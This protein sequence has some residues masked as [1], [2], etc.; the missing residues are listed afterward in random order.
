MSVKNRWRLMAEDGKAIMRNQHRKFE[1]IKY[2]FVSS[3]IATFSVMAAAGLFFGLHLSEWSERQGKL[4]GVIGSI[5]GVAGAFFGALTALN[6]PSRRNHSSKF[7]PPA[8]ARD[9]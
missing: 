4:V 8:A 9:N 3:M 2:A 6:H 7:E 5:A 1:A